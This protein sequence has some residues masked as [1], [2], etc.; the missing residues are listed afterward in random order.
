MNNGTKNKDIPTSGKL[1]DVVIIRSFAIILVVAFHAYGMMHAEAHFPCVKTIYY[2]YYYNVNDLALKFRM[3]LFVFISGYLFS[4]LEKAK[5]K[6]PTFKD[7]FNN[8]F[9]RLI[10]PYFVFAVVYMLT[11]NSFSLELLFAGGTAHLWFITMLFWCFIFTR[12][13]SFVPYNNHLLFKFSL[14]ALSFCFLFPTTNFLPRFMGLYNVSKWYFWFY[15]GYVVLPYREQLFN[16]LSCSW[17]RI[18]LLL[19]GGYGI[20]FSIK[21]GEYKVIYAQVGYLSIVLLIWYFIN[22]IIQKF[23][24]KWLDSSIFKELNRTSYGIFVLHNWLQLFMISKLSQRLFHLDV[25]AENHVVLFP[26]CFFLLSLL[27][28]YIG[29]VMILKTKVGR[30]LIG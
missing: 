29:S 28:S 22:Y 15:L 12:L 4:Y 18:L 24:G 14:L 26:L 8:K 17:T 30:F 9:K 25:L 2:D 19:L 3:P 23:P 11:T 13:L 21:T 7:L 1:Y 10:I 5:G 6:Y 20:Y 27:F 16:W